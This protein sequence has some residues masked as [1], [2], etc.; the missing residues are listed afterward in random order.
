MHRTYHQRLSHWPET[1]FGGSGLTTTDGDLFGVGA[2]PRI[3]SG[4]SV[5]APGSALDMS[6]GAFNSDGD[7]SSDRNLSCTRSKE[8]GASI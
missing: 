8:S 7:S 3:V 4:I 6:S 5:G 2:R 1:R